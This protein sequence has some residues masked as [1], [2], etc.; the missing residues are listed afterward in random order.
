MKALKIVLTQNKAHYKKEEVDQNKLTYPLP[1]FSTIIGALHYACG[2]KEYKAMNLSVQGKYNTLSK[3]TY[4]D[5]CFHD[6]ID[7]DRAILVKLIDKYWQS[8]AFIKIAK[9]PKKNKSNFITGN[10]LEIYNK[11]LLEEYQSLKKLKVKLSEF[12]KER[13]DKIKNLIKIR[14]KSIEKKMKE[15]DKK[16]IEFLFLSKRK[17]EIIKID[18]LID[19]NFEEFQYENYTKENEKYKLV[20][21]SPK[22]YEI[23]H[24]IKLIIHI[25]SDEKTLEAIK[26]NIYC[27][28]SIGR[29]EDFVDVQE[30]E[31]VE[32]IDEVEDEIRSE[33]SA[34]LNYDLV[35]KKS[36][37]LNHRK[38]GIPASGT[39]YWINKVY[40]KSKGY[41]DFKALGQKVK[42]VYGSNFL[43]DD[44]SEGV[45]FDGDYIVN[46]N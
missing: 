40:D 27:L 38:D 2:F 13:I 10:A 15:F 5:H 24:E 33:Y 36:I 43:I 17:E 25:D 14:K 39:K 20:T 21:T 31:Y 35:K 9:A 7:N 29:S 8:K 16:S 32:L 42:V 37:L 45:Y 41:R 26:E 30:C 44:E 6:K 23:L 19:K 12:K 46:F 3:Q 22:S 1:P 28:K 11:E 18:L 34:Y 4:I